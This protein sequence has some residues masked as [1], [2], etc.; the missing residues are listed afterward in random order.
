[1]EAKA[2]DLLNMIV[3]RDITIY[4]LEQE[5]A[6]FKKPEEKNQPEKEKEKQKK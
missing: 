4:K 6:A 5:L 2:E 3:H 1:M